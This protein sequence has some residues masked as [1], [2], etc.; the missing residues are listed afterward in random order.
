MGADSKIEWT[1]HTFNP[2]IGCTAVSPACDHCY[3]EVSTPARALGVA[4]GPN[5]ERRRTSEATWRQ[6]LAWNRKAQREGRRFK[7]FCASLADV[8]DNQVPADWRADLWA[9]IASTPHLD[10][11]LLT[12]RPQN[13]AKMLPGAY[14][15]QLVGRDLPAWPWPNVWLG[16]TVENQA[17]ADRRI[18]HLLA[19]PAA[20]RFLSMEP[21][22]GPVDLSAAKALPIY[23]EAEHVTVRL[24]PTTIPGN[25]FTRPGRGWC[26]HDGNMQPWIDWVIAGGE[27]GPKARPSHP[28]WFRSL[29]DQCQAAGV[30][31]FHKQNGEWAPGE[32]CDGPSTRT[33][34][35]AWWSDDHW[36]IDR[37]TPSDTVGLHIDDEPDVWRA[38][39]RRTGATLDG[40][41][42][43]EVP[44]G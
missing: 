13:I 6:P 30:P 40:R 26:R 9:L 33:E 17:E 1:D 7:V 42:W 5:A 23:R 35:V 28:D 43:R 19:V 36:D 24:H 4:W 12:K 34:E 38:G 25:V 14:V 2:W 37:M 11:L 15:E 22:L 39:K 8:F 3:A 16:T 20:K 18:Q 21:L 41:E 32:A 10:W 27:S 44:S 31:Y 29:R